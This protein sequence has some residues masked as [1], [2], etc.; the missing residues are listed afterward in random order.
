[1]LRRTPR[2][3]VHGARCLLLYLSFRTLALHS[4]LSPSRCTRCARFASAPTR[5]ARVFPQVAFLAGIRRHALRLQAIVT[6]YVKITSVLPRPTLRFR[7]RLRRL[8]T[9][10]TVDVTFT[11]STGGVTAEALAGHV[12]LYLADASNGV[13]TD[14]AG[15]GGATVTTEV[16]SAPA[17]VASP[18]RS[19]ANTRGEP[20]AGLIVGI[21]VSALV[22]VA[23]VGIIA[24]VVVMA[25][26]LFVYKKRQAA[27]AADVATLDEKSVEMGALPDS[28]AM[29]SHP[30]LEQTDAGG[31]QINILGENPLRR[32]RADIDDIGADAAGEG[33][34]VDAATGC[35]TAT[36]SRW[37]HTTQ[38]TGVVYDVDGALG[39]LGGAGTE[40]DHT[41]HKNPLHKAP[42]LTDDAAAE[43]TAAADAANVDLSLPEGW[44]EREHE[45]NVFWKNMTTGEKS[46][47]HPVALTLPSCWELRDHDG[48]AFYK[49]VETGEKS[50][51]HPSEIAATAAL[52]A[53]WEQLQHKGTSIYENSAML[54][55][56]A[57]KAG[58]PSV[59]TTAAA[60]KRSRPIETDEWDAGDATRDDIRP[61]SDGWYYTDVDAA[62]ILHGPVSIA[63]LKDWLDDG[64]FQRSDIVRHGRDGKDVT[65][66]TLVRVAEDGRHYT[67]VEFV[68]HSGGTDEWDA[69]GGVRRA[70]L[71]MAAATTRTSGGSMAIEVTSV[72]MYADPLHR[73]AVSAGGDIRGEKDAA[74]A[75][76]KVVEEAL[77]RSRRMTA[78]QSAAAFAGAFAGF[79]E[80]APADIRPHS[81]GWYYTDVDAASIL[82]GPVSI[83]ALKDWLD[84]GHFQRSDIVRHGRDGKDVTL[85]TLVRVAENGGHYTRVEFVEHYGGTDEW[86]AARTR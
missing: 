74:A 77:P 38:R 44:E 8:S 53:G 2:V 67:R 20:D 64:H 22:A 27:H 50:W 69:E 35:I 31:A 66:S 34:S 21:I 43:S 55:N 84:D 13:A 82:H 80:E 5:T 68:E 26:A 75:K 18:S 54:P 63:A 83:A 46:W 33:E 57:L 59:S 17:A 41:V 19:Q 62:S 32:D 71:A 9:H 42:L 60:A 1:M 85:S 29:G 73:N 51:E 37:Q 52:P 24:F 78:E 58:Q 6:A 48:A 72:P 65:L 49:N 56:S 81:D 11:V 28:L 30:E 40:E 45:G 12:A 86:D 10:D 14:I 23:V 4:C 79:D 7:E 61:H 76:K 70:E 25:A 3:Y 39:A 15:G 47:T 36:A 16:I